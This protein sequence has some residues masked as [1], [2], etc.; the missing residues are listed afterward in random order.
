[1][2]KEIRELI[3]KFQNLGIASSSDGAMLIGQVPHKGTEAWLNEMF[4]VLDK[5]EIESLE[6][7]LDTSIPEEYKDFL[8]N[9][10][11]GLILLTATLSFDGLRRHLTRDLKANSRQPFSIITPNIYER[12]ENALKSYFFIGGY[13]WDGSLLYIDKETNIVHCCAPDDATSKVQW[14]SFKEML[15]SELKRLYLLFDDEGKEINEDV[16]TLPY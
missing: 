5:S 2:Y 16:S 8:Q 12:P 4:P 6:D 11:N 13:Q 7:E 9:F 14:S 10:S 1:M 3:Y 15:Q